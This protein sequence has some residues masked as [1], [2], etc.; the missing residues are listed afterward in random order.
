MARKTGN[1][2][3]LKRREFV[4]ATLGGVAATSLAAFPGILRAQEKY[5]FRMGHA[6]AVGSPIT[7]AFETWGKM[8][9]ERSGGRI[10]AQHFP[11]GQLGNYT[12]LVEGNRLGT[13]QATAGGPDTEEAVAPEIA[14]TGGAPGF[15]YKDEAHVDRVLQGPIG[16]EVSRIAREKTGVEFVAYA[17]VG[18]RH[19]L[20]KRKVVALDELSGLKIRVPELRIWIDFWKGLGANPT[21]LPYAEQYNA[22]STGVIDALEADFFSIKGFKWFEQAK[23]LTLTY[24][25]FLPKAVRVNA[26]WLDALPDDLRKLVRDSAKAVFAEQR[27]QNRARAGQALQELKDLGTNVYPVASPE[28]WL[29]KAKPLFADY[30]Q[31]H[32]SAKPMIDKIIAL[33]EG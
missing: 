3:V 21:P 18:F 29:A 8:L 16:E 19:L 7:E 2:V 11:A 15:I 33:R 24:H 32:P 13:I 9:R 30:G 26:K 28:A 25:W 17:E 10:E 23:H 5:T 22:L 6:E 14:V 1:Y 12:Q 27:A 20:T 31:K 4:K